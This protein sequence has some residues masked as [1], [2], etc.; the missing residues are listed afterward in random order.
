[1]RA[2]DFISFRKIVLQ[3]EQSSDPAAVKAAKAVEMISFHS[4]SK[5]FIGECGI[6]GGY[7]ELYNLDAAV[8]ANLYKLASIS[9]CKAATSILDVICARS[10][11]RR[12]ARS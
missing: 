8:K 2:Q 7:F 5:G 9:L 6:R 1:M 10:L 4:V 3:M 12:V 11:L